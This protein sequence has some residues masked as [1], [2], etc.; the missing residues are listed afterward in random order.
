VA[1][2]LGRHHNQQ[3]PTHQDKDAAVHLRHITLRSEDYPTREAYPFSLPI[4]QRT[5]RVEFTAPVTFFVGENGTGKSTLLEAVA[6]RCAIHIW[7]GMERT[8]YEINRYEDALACYVDAE[9]AAGPV[10]GSFF[11]SQIFRHFAQLLDEMAAADPGQLA[12]FGG[13]S[14]ITQ[15]HGQSLMAFFRARYGIRG[16]YLL[17]EPETALS[18]RTQVDLV[19]MLGAMTADGHAQFIVATH[20]PILMACPGATLYSFDGPVVAPVRYEDTS[21]FRVYRDFLRDPAAALAAAPPPAA[22]PP[23]P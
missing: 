18:P 22:A 20:S 10:P 14:L 4:L 6:R 17:D 1:T 15:S 19:R 5:R 8:R 23:A 13:R 11:A 12:Y 9:W 3:D 16:L 21:H 7:E 2:L